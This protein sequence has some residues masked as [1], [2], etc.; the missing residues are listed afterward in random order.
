MLRRLQDVHGLE[1]NPLLV[2]VFVATS[3]YSKRDIPANITELFKKFTEMMLGRWDQRKGLSQQYQAP[4]KDHLL[5]KL[6]FNLHINKNIEISISECKDFFEKCLKEMGNEGDLNILFDEIVYRSGLLKL[7]GNALSFRHTLL[8]E[9]YAGRGVPNSDY[10]LSVISED[11]WKHPILFYFGENPEKHSGIV[12]LTEKMQGLEGRALYQAAVAI[13]VAVQA[14]YLSK[15]SDKSKTVEWVIDALSSSRK[16][17]IEELI[18][19]KPNLPNCA[20]IHFYLYARD[21]VACDAIKE[22]AEEKINLIFSKQ[23]INEMEEAQVFW[24]IIAL[25]EIGELEKAFS[26]IKKF[27]PKDLKYLL[28]I[29]VGCFVISKLKTYT[30]QNRGVAEDIC[31]FINPKIDYLKDDVMKEMNT[32]F[33]ELQ[34]GHVVP[35]SDE[36]KADEISK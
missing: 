6:G 36:R 1:L 26:F 2:T 35:I 23:T 3:D 28:S 27:K 22:N 7:D 32:L 21:A 30:N 18:A 10:F 33:L 15:T 12:S 9:F 34:H 29:H 4:L 8:Q 20:F 17:V 25:I 14:C 16:G 5:K 11:W 19:E 31:K 24:Y 13:G